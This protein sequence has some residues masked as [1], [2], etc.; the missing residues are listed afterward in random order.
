MDGVMDGDM[1]EEMD[2]VMDEVRNKFSREF[3]D[4]EDEDLIYLKKDASNKRKKMK[5]SSTKYK[6]FVTY[7][8]SGEEETI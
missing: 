6:K 5:T 7:S 8:N 4:G 2:G 3:G 1:D